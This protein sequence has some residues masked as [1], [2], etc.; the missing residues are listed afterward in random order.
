MLSRRRLTG[1]ALGALLLA[2]S[3]P[4]AM[5]AQP[6]LIGGGAADSL[7][8]LAARQICALVNEH[9]RA[10]Y[11]CIA[12]PAPGSLFNIRAIEVALMEFGFARP[13]RARDAVDGS[14]AWE[15][16][17]VAGLRSVFA[18][19]AATAEVVTGAEVAEDL[20]YDTVRIVFENL[21]VLRSAHPAFAE[22]APAAMLEGLAAPLHPGAARYYLEQG[23]LPP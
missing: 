11:G 9:A 20:V 5:A 3:V 1:A 21:G 23:W 22:L 13:D 6:M 19:R 4:Q 15:G 2:G 14:G 16:A 18:M 10:R 8:T 12:H 17:P 7:Q